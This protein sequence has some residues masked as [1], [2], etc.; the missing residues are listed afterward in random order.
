MLRIPVLSVFSLGLVACGNLAPGPAIIALSPASPTTSDD[1]VVTIDTDAF[2]P[3][4]KGLDYT[5]LWYREGELVGRDIGPTLSAEYTAKDE[6]WRVEV[7][8]SDGKAD[9][10]AI[11]AQVTIGNSAPSVTLTVSPEEPYSADDIEVTAQA[12]DPD[13]DAVS[14][15]WSWTRDGQPT[16]NS[17]GTI[18]ASETSR[19]QLWE[20]TVTP[21]DGDLEGEPA[22]AS[23]SIL[24]SAPTV[25]SYD[26]GPD[27]AYEDDILRVEASFD[28]ADRDSV[29]VVYAWYVDDTLEL[30]GSVTT[31]SGS[32]FDKHQEVYVEIRPT[33][34]IDS[35]TPVTTDAVT[36]SN[37]P[38]SLSGVSISPTE[39]YESST[40]TCEVDGLDDVDGDDV[41]TT[42][43]W[44]VSGSAV[45]TGE[46]LDG[47]NFDR[48]DTVSCTVET[49]DGEDDG[50]TTSSSTLTVL[51]SLPVVDSVSISPDPPTTTDT[52]TAS[53]V[54]GSD[55]DGDTVALDYAW[56]LNGSL[57]AITSELSSSATTKHDQLELQVTPSDG[58]DSGLTVSSGLV[59]V[60]N[61]P[62]TFTAVTLSDDEASL[63]GSLTVY[64]SGWSD[65]DGDAAG[66]LYTWYGNGV[67]VGTS[68]TL[69]LTGL[70][71]GTELY[72]QVTA[73]DGDDPGT[74]IDSDTL[75]IQHRLYDS[76]AD[77]MLIGEQGDEAGRAVGLGSDITGDGFGDVAVGAPYSDLGGSSTGALYIASQP[78]G[79]TVDL[80]TSA[81]G[82]FYSDADSLLGWSLS[83]AGDIDA[84]GVGD[85]V[86]GAPGVSIFGDDAGAAYVVHGPVSGS[87]SIST[88][89]WEFGGTSADAL[90]GSSVSGAGDLDADGYDDVVVGGYGAS[91]EAGEAYV[92][93]GPVTAGGLLSYVDVVLTGEAAGDEAGYCV[94]GAGDTDGDGMDDLIVGAT[95][96]SSGG[97]QAG[98][99]YIVFGPT[100]SGDIGTVADVK[101]T[102]EH[103]W[104]YA[105]YA[106]DG[107][108]DT[109]GDGLEDVLVTSRYEDSGGATA[110]AAYLVLG[111]VSGTVSL[112]SADAKLLGSAANELVGSSVA[113]IGD[114]DVDGMD[115]FLLG[116]EGG[117]ISGSSSGTVY[118]LQGPLTGTF[119][120][121]EISDLVVWGSSAGDKLGIAVAGDG[122][123]D[124]D[125]A[126]DI[127]LGAPFEDTAGS[128][129]GAAYLFLG[130]SI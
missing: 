45:A 18:L 74:S 11:G 4:G 3:E 38:P 2:D 107:V 89:G 103:T 94:A 5:Y 120:L 122:D 12:S 16:G 22:V 32:Y 85:L 44:T 39:L 13:D 15:D 125:G 26:L 8:A 64:P 35:G 90:G 40:A 19:Y 25:T 72:C 126:I 1:L 6:L 88:V 86:V 124:G 46:T 41:T 50:P 27:P 116:A 84:D 9:G 129:S 67:A 23:V 77:T 20:V 10:P 68:A 37:S 30:E 101:L 112:A 43:T 123:V 52:L 57:R 47:D 95:G 93:Y 34:G 21:S 71:V 36:I 73:W 109:D 55:D 29:T 87:G 96:E 119:D 130:S 114:F 92:I 28:D 98:A 62:P 81:V 105:G 48:G 104:D 99:A 70:H 33:D 83:F 69:D 17:T 113:G 53:V 54:G 24:N 91:S 65:D 110:G 66:Y 117:D 79:T 108:G 128:S 56:Y 78:S 58:T 31:L 75:V 51:N 102:G 7:V 97:T 63:G 100:V 42:I 80:K 118:M 111:G 106:V 14:L 76:D 61:T 60:A 59:T 121:D 127:V 49:T 115:D 82:A